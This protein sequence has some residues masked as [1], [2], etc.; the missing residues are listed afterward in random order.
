MTHLQICAACGQPNTR[1]RVVVAGF[2]CCGRVRCFATW[3]P[4]DAAA[5]ALKIKARGGHPVLQRVGHK[6][7]V[8]TLRIAR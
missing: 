2:E 5:K 1:D 3:A 4:R 6:V 8:R 7:L